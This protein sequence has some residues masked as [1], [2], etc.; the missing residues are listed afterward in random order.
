MYTGQVHHVEAEVLDL[1]D[2]EPSDDDAFFFAHKYSR[3]A[4]NNFSAL[5]FSMKMAQS[6]KIVLKSL[7]VDFDDVQV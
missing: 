6:G 3:F 2:S 5:F 7:I 1:V 4:H